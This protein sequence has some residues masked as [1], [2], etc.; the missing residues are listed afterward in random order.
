MQLFGEHCAINYKSCI[1]EAF[2]TSPPAYGEEEEEEPI[3]PE[4][5]PSTNAG[6]VI[7]GEYTNNRKEWKLEAK[8]IAEH[9]RQVFALVYAQLS[10]SSRSEVKDHE[11]WE[12]T[13]LERNLLFLIERIRATRIARQ[14]G[15][16]AQDIERV[17]TNWANM[18]MFPNE[19]SFTFRKKVEDYQLK[20][21]AVGLL[22]I[23]DDELVIGILNRLDMSR[24]ALLVR[25]YLDNERRGIAN[26]PELPSTL[27]TE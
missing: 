24:Y 20:R 17:R 21:T 13:F 15:N 27:W 19:T 9:R 22:E 4:T 1:P 18:R 26:L 23:P 6:K 16:P 12:D 7:L 5:I 14:S 2:W 10:E 3:L 25:D 8:K 11:E